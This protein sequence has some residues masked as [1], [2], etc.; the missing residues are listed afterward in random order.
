MIGW[1][2][3]EFPE[4]GALRARVED[5][6]PREGRGNEGK[7]EEWEKEGKPRSTTPAG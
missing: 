7:E 3:T 2:R 4:Q 5:A 6:E 1:A